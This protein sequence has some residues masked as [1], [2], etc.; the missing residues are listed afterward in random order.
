MTF[1]TSWGWRLV[2]SGANPV[3]CVYVCACA[4]MCSQAKLL[5][6][7]PTLCYPMDCSLLGSFVHGILQART[8]RWVAMHSSRGSSWPRD[9]TQWLEGWNFQSHPLKEE[10]C[11]RFLIFTNIILHKSEQA[12][13]TI[14]KQN[15]WPHLHLQLCPIFAIPSQKSSLKISLLAVTNFSSPFYLLLIPKNF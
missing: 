4:R 1:R 11:V 9:Q 13:I 5:Q 8:L 6:S 15:S 3:M 14:Q 2:T 10:N 7:C 12:W